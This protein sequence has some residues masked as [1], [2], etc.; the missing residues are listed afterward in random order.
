MTLPK[1]DV[2]I[3]EVTLP[4]NGN[5]IKIRPFVVKEEKLLLMAIES[6]DNENIIK[7]TKQVINNC[8]VSGDLDLEKMPFFDVDY[9]FIALRAKSIGESIETSYVCNN[10]V[11]G[12]KCGGIF[13]T[14]IDISNCTIE[15]KDDIT[16]DISLSNKLSMK[17]KYPSYSIMKM[18]SSNEN[19]FQKKIRIIASCIERI[20]NGDQVYSSKDFSKEELVNFIDGL[21]REQFV[22]LENFVDNL[23]SF[24]IQTGGVCPK[25]GSEHKIKYTDFTRFFQ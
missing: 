19:N 15:K 2:P 4:S 5:T 10:M 9:L 18:I 1:I 11:D 16:M 25:C 7:T 21:T 24:A 20:T 22:K 3:Y 12:N 8:I 6:G 13:D 17:M 23:P 14:V